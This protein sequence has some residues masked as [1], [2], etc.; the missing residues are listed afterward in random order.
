MKHLT[1][2]EFSECLTA[3]L[4][5]P[6]IQAHLAECDACRTELSS[7]M[8][9]MDDFGSAAMDWSRAQPVPSVR[10]KI[11]KTQPGSVAPLRWALAAALIA[12]VGV[13]VAVHR[14]RETAPAAAE[15]DAG[16]SAAQIAQD[17]RLLESVNVAL[18]DSDPSPLSE[19][20][21]DSKTRAGAGTRT[22]MRGE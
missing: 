11:T 21:L 6:A 18:A 15:V 19:Y 13:P 3:A 1:D 14:E 17:N 2:A 7:F 8:A 4:P 12:A 10:A 22:R 16:D 9:A 20:G 5:E